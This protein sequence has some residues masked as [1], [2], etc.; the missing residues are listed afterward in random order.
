MDKELMQILACPACRGELVELGAAELEG[1]AC[2]AC[3]LVYP[4][5]DQIP[6]LLKEEAVPRQ[7]WD[8][9]KRSRQR[10]QKTI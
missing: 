8:A 3:A 2:P 4:L 5:R 9:G 7:D 10:G 1:L 6:V